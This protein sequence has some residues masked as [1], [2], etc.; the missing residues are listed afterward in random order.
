MTR[1]HHATEQTIMERPLELDGGCLCGAVRYRVSGPM[2][3]SGT[4]FCRTCRL[5]A[6]AQSVAWFVVP[7]DR[8]VFTAGR[9]TTFHSSPEVTRGF[10]GA[11]GTSLT[12]QHADAAD[13]I[14]LTTASLDEPQH[15]PP[16]HEIWHAHRV[17]WAA[18]NE[19][20][21]RFLRDSQGERLDDG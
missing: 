16:R 6:G 7:A 19:A 3:S 4:C 15:V 17:S 13:E 2:L 20:I 14:E 5:A 8:C 9:M 18:S 11:C 1:T 21:P 12:Y 10:C